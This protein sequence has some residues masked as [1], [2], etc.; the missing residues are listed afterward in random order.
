MVAQAGQLLDQ[1]A[2]AAA[3]QQGRNGL[4]PDGILAGMLWETSLAYLFHGA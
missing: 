2:F 3:A 4:P 1:L